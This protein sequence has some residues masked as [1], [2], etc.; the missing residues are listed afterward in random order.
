MVE[1]FVTNLYLLIARKFSSERIIWL[2]SDTQKIPVEI[3]IPIAQ[4][5]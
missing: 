4:T 3:L 2:S 1:P 5:I